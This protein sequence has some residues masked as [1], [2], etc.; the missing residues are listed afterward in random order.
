[1]RLGLSAATLWLGV[2]GFAWLAPALKAQALPN[3]LTVT[4][5]TAPIYQADQTITTSGT[6]IV[7]SGSSVTFQAGS[8][9]KL[10]QGFHAAVGSHFHAAL[11]LP[12]FIISVAPAA[13]NSGA[14]LVG[15][16][17]TYTVTATGIFNFSGPVGFNIAGLPAG[18]TATLNPQ[19]VSVPANGSASATLTIATATGGVTG[20]YSFGVTGSSVSLVHSA[21]GSLSVQDFTLSISPSVVSLLNGGTATYQI[22]AGSIS[23]F[24]GTISLFITWITPNPCANVAFSPSSSIQAGGEPHKR[25]LK[26]CQAVRNSSMLVAYEATRGGP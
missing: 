11:A 15:G 7:N 14:V 6:V 9:I 21:T 2:C 20:N 12:D 10:E 24:N 3:N 18:A 22:T 13:G 25:L 8:T 4:S 26:D 19:S 1:M 17:T 23:G 16:S 5:A